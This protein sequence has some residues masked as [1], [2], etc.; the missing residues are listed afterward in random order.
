MTF[1]IHYDDGRGRRSYSN[2]YDENVER[3]IDAAWDDVYSKFPDAAY[4][5]SF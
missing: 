5:E 1:I 2:R 3:E 4:I